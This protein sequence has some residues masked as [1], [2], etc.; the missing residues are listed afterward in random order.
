MKNRK[1]SLVLFVGFLFL[2]AF[3]PLVATQRFDTVYL[4]KL[5]FV[6]S[7]GAEMEG[8][9]IDLDLDRD[10]SITADTDD[11]IDFEVGGSDVLSVTTSGLVMGSGLDAG[12]NTIINIGAAGTDFSAAGGLTLADTL[13]VTGVGTFSND[14]SVDDTFNIDDTAYSS[15]GAQ[16]LDPTAS[17]YLMSPA[18]TLTLTLATTTSV[19]GDFVWFMSQVATDI[20]IVDTT[21]TAGGGNR[22]LGSDGDTIGF[23]YDG[24]KWCEA[25]YSDNS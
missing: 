9:K 15:V 11:Q 25:F 17:M 12:T 16:T 4:K 18:T 23:I 14:L 5:R 24:S 19:A 1:L 7:A 13:G 3:A 20:V 21:C 22:T 8:N 6:G 2:V 10:T